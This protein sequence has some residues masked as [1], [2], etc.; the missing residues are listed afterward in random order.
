MMVAEENDK[1]QDAEHAKSHSPECSEEAVCDG[2]HQEGETPTN[3]VPEN[4]EMG[5]QEPQHQASGIPTAHKQ[6]STE[7]AEK[8]HKHQEAELPKANMP[9]SFLLAEQSEHEHKC[10]GSE[11]SNTL[12]P[13]SPVTILVCT[14]TTDGNTGSTP[15]KSE[16]AQGFI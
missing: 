4:P 6:E 5:Q 1:H 9:E 11:L 16:H 12:V 7:I 3:I 13:G 2:K 15:K 10:S 8:E 14:A